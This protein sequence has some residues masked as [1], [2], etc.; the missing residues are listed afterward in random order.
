[1]PVV[2]ISPVTLLA[3]D[4][5]RANQRGHTLRHSPRLVQVQNLA[6]Q[7]AGDPSDVVQARASRHHTYASI[8]YEVV[9][10]TLLAT[11]LSQDLGT[12]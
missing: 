1:M 4:R 6:G 12:M 10:P 5:T 7:P 2:N 8:L 11:K 3:T 9:V